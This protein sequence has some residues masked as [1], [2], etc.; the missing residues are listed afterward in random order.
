MGSGALV[1][2]WSHP[3]NH[4]NNLITCALPPKSKK[5]EHSEA[6][7]FATETPYFE[8]SSSQILFFTLPVLSDSQKSPPA[9]KARW[10]RNKKTTKYLR[11]PRNTWKSR[12]HPR[13]ARF[14]GEFRRD[15]VQ[16]PLTRTHRCTPLSN[17][18]FACAS[19]RLNGSYLSSAR[20]FEA[21]AR[22]RV[23]FL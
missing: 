12:G 22:L 16:F 23:I 4:R 5:P 18:S 21:G 10:T 17:N 3:F 8:P 15:P 7:K 2:V 9:V 19:T 20:E 14:R 13:R 1:L 6:R 11:N